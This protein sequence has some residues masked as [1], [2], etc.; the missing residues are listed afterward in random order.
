MSNS[1]ANALPLVEN[2]PKRL[3]TVMVDITMALVFLVVWIA[4]RPSGVLSF[5]VSVR[6]TAVVREL[7]CR[8]GWRSVSLRQSARCGRY[9]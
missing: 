1:A 3:R 8:D 6:L 4:P 5:G 9:R 7:S 2:V